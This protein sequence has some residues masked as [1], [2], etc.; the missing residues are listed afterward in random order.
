MREK[1][2]YKIS[3]KLSF[4][5]AAMAE[6]LSCCLHGIDLCNIETG[7]TVLVIGGGPIGL[8]MLQLARNAGASKVILSEPV[9]EKR[10]LALNLGADMVINPIEQNV[11]EELSNTVKC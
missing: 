3:D 6:P 1:Q 5:E 8:I 7:D 2:V 11:Q 4:E 10:E 9:S